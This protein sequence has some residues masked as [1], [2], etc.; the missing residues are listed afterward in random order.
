MSV[1]DVKNLEI[2]VN[3]KILIRDLTF[4][5][6]NPAFV[7]I[8]GH[9]GC[10]K[11]SFLKALLNLLPYRGEI[12]L[13]DS[14]AFLEQKNNI[15]FDI[16]AKELAVMGRFQ[17]KKFFDHYSD[18]DYQAVENVFKN[19][20]ALDFLNK[21]ILQLSGGEQQLVWLAQAL[22]QN[23]SI[24][25][26]DEPTQYLDIY[27]RKK[28]FSLL[29][30]LVKDEH[31]TV[32]CI[33]HDLLNLYQLEGYILNLSSPLPSLITISKENVEK[34]QIELERLR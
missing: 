32:M 21:S 7:A 9:N 14:P 12:F 25:L 23:S 3:Q 29:E 16:P 31:K 6:K 8:I 15:R 30:R 10:G 4:E 1:I 33:T 22:L 34:M 19:L 2:T 5:L 27:N 26:L 24:L 13:S 20:G 17:Q 11:T 28:V 18:E